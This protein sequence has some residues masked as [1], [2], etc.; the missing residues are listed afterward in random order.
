MPNS[1]RARRV[2]KKARRAKDKWANDSLFSLI[3]EEQMPRNNIIF[4]EFDPYKDRTPLEH[5]DD[6]ILV[7]K[8]YYVMSTYNFWDLIPVSLRVRLK[9]IKRD[10]ITDRAIFQ[11]NLETVLPP[12]T[13][14]DHIIMVEEHYM[15]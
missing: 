9:L 3:M 5:R 15:D 13:S 14:P 12:V 1:R 10:S 11:A 8:D 4:V 6:G 7:R 2:A